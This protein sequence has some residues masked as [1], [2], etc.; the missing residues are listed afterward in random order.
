MGVHAYWNKTIGLLVHL[1]LMH[2]GIVSLP[3]VKDGECIFFLPVHKPAGLSCLGIRPM[4][5]ETEVSI[6]LMH[7]KE[8]RT[9]STI[10]AAIS[11]ALGRPE[12]KPRAAL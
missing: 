10:K 8:P 12:V 7:W 2:A 1:D 5:A 9:L 4:L 11:G 3:A 6:L